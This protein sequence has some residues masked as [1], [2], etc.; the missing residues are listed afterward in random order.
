MSDYVTRMR[1]LIGSRPLLQCGSAV[2]AIDRDGRI[3]LHHRTDNDTWGLPG[4]S[5]EIGERLEECAVRETR[6]EVGLTCQS[7]ELFGVY[8][9]PEL[10]YRYANGDE[11]H[12]VTVVYLCRDSSGTIR[13]DPAEGKDAAFFAV[14]DIPAA[15]SPPVRPVIEDYCHRCQRPPNSNTWSE[16]SWRGT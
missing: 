7:L 8:S 12:N 10:Y 15:I 5:M 6:E 9:G 2:I 1:Q 4:G 13:V 14:E 11:A 16:S 3:L